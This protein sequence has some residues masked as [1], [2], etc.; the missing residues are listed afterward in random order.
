VPVSSSS[1][2][3]AGT[4]HRQGIARAMVLK[5]RRPPEVQ[6]TNVEPGRCWSPHLHIVITR[7]TGPRRAELRSRWKVAGVRRLRLRRPALIRFSRLVSRT[8]AI[9]RSCS[10]TSCGC[11]VDKGVQDR[12]AAR[13]VPSSVL[14]V[15]LELL[16]RTQLAA[17]AALAFLRFSLCLLA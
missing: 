14:P 12:S 1:V 2:R 13:P 8:S 11:L 5:R 3:E 10:G 6:S 4:I 16:S 9:R 17:V 15:G 7:P